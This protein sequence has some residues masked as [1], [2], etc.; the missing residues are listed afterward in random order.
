[1][2]CFRA[3]GKNDD[4]VHEVH[5]NTIEGLWM[6]ACN[7]LHPF[8]G[9]HKK[10]LHASLAMGDHKINLKRISPQFLAQ[11]VAQHKSAP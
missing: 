1:M 11:L 10:S 2:R 5:V 4:G 3:Q 8:R 6:T 9:V 7:L